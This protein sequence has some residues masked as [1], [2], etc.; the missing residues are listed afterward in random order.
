MSTQAVM[1]CGIVTIAAVST[2]AS[3]NA[4]YQ[5]S[6]SASWPTTYSATVPSSGGV[7]SGQLELHVFYEMDGTNTAR[8]LTTGAAPTTGHGHLLPLNNA[9]N[10][11]QGFELV[12]RG[13]EDCVNFKTIG[14]ASGINVT[15]YLAVNDDRR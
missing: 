7:A 8:F 3:I 13:K 1:P 5:P 4:S 15:W 2:P 9:L 10:V 12:I 11:V 14:T 6:A